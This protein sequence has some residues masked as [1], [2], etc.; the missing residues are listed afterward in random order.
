MK[1]RESPLPEKSFSRRGGAIVVPT[2]GGGGAR[3]GKRAE[4]AIAPA[5][6]APYEAFGFVAK[7]YGLNVAQG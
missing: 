5:T 2:R 3:E 1:A 6:P 4:T 7:M